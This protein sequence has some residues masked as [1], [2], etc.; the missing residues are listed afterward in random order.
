MSPAFLAP[1][2]ISATFFFCELGHPSEKP[3]HLCNHLEPL[4]FR[5]APGEKK[6]SLR[7]PPVQ[8]GAKKKARQ[9]RVSGADAQAQLPCGDE[10]PGLRRLAN[11][12]AVQRRPAEIFASARRF[13]IEG[14]DT[15]GV[16]H[17]GFGCFL[18]FLF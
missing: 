9:R 8:L 12:G 4:G 1:A 2:S 10:M 3:T 7:G 6:G 14:R 17:A 13:D 11:P 18:F 16:Q 15:R 5:T